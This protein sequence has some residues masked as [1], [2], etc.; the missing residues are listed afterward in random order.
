MSAA[1]E[2]AQRWWETRA[3]LAAALLLSMM[4]LLWPTVPPLYD[5]PDHLG[6][7]HVMADIAGSP[8]LQ[9][10][11]TF[12]WAL[13]PNL[14]VDLLVLALA[15]LLGVVVATKLV[16]MAIPA[17]TVLA[18][19]VLSRV[20]TGRVS[21]AIGF[22]LPLAYAAPFHMGFVN[23][24]LSAALALLALG[25]WIAMGRRGRPW[26]RT[27]VFAPVVFGLWLVHSSGWGLFGILAFAADWQRHKASGKSWIAAGWAAAL[28]L[29][30]LAFPIGLMMMGPG[31]ENGLAAEWQWLGKLLWLMTVLRDRWMWFDILSVAV[32]LVALYV[33]FRS[34]S[35]RFDARLGWPALAALAT[36]LAL[37]WLM[38]GG[39][40]VDMRLL[41]IALA[42][43]LL[44]ITRRP[45]APGEAE[46]VVAVLGAV[47]FVQRMAAA[48]ASLFIAGNLQAE[49]ASVL[50]ALPRGAAVL[51]LVKE[52]CM[53][54]WDSPRFGHIGGLAV[55]SRDAFVNTQWTL[56]GQQLVRP[57]HA[58]G[59][60]SDPS[61]FI[62]P[63][64]CPEHPIGLGRVLRGFDRGLFTHVW[65]LDFP[66]DQGVTR[67]ITP[68]ARAGRSVLYRVTPRR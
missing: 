58:G 21:P 37:P 55:V 15:P 56:A 7:Y 57:R 28:P 65:M 68:V 54:A 8:D 51:V 19:F 9:R 52:P 60:V 63:Y 6:R 64:S 4:P 46:G 23:Y 18:L 39:A 36:F 20:A 33:G 41:P 34:P 30:P 66:A 10:H 11:W 45:G 42:L 49:A 14:G 22:A 31:S 43:G 29:A 32:M 61:Q 48:T 53:V 44:A 62:R 3:A 17:L 40:Y 2:G 1:A 25:G 12:E 5:L 67:D 38:V 26:L 50:P 59:F 35:M 47:F 16:V 24:C 13:V 27:A